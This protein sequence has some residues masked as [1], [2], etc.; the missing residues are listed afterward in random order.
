MTQLTLVCFALCVSIAI[1]VAAPQSQLAGI[2]GIDTTQFIPPVPQGMD[3]N[4]ISQYQ[5]YMQNLFTLIQNQVN[6]GGDSS[7][8]D[9]GDKTTST[10]SSSASSSA[11]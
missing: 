9:S 4:T 5:N 7:G 8:G 11:A 1:T 6:G 3:A 10:A 2:G